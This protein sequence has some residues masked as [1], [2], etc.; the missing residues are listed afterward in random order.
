MAKSQIFV[1]SYARDFVWLEYLLR[2][3]DRY[4]VDFL[5][6]VVAVPESDESAAQSLAARVCPRAH[7]RTQPEC[8]PR[9]S[10][11]RRFLSAQVAMMES[12]VLCPEADFVWLFGSDCFVHGMLTPSM[13]LGS[14]GRA[15]MPYSPYAALPI[16]PQ[17]WRAS[18]EHLIQVPSVEFEF[19]RRLPLVYPTELY[20][21][22]RA[23]VETAFGAPFRE[24]VYD[25]ER[26]GLKASE[27]N[28][29]G[30]YAW[31][32]WRDAF[33]WV[34]VS[35]VPERDAVFPA[36]QFWSHGGPDLPCDQYHRYFGQTP[37]QFM[38]RFLA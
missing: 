26:R 22:M 6:P 36:I 23:H 10:K 19:M 33:E 32:F 12:D 1:A 11:W 25:T 30:A 8:P 29:L 2:S 9:A 3:V 24:V 18:T 28:V 16:G 20:R 15:V 38:D 34:D 13:G 37:R 35:R 21:R 17:C 14:S 27:S 31:Y 7:V 5:P 4:A